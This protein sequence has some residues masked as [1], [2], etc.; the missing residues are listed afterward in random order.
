MRCTRFCF[1]LLLPGLGALAGPVHADGLKTGLWQSTLSQ[2]NALGSVRPVTRQIC[3]SDMSVRI[4]QAEQD[5]LKDRATG[6]DSCKLT[7]HGTPDDRS[8]ELACTGYSAS[9]SF[10]QPDPD[11]FTT[12]NAIKD[13]RGPD[14]ARFGLTTTRLDYSWVKAD[15]G[16]APEFR[17]SPTIGGTDSAPMSAVT[18]FRTGQMYERGGNGFAQ[19]YGQAMQHYLAAAAQGNP[20]AEFRIGYLYEKG[21]GVP[22]DF[23]Q[24][25]Q[26]YAKA[27]AHGNQTAATREENLKARQPVQ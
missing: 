23:N 5:R 8:V 1:W 27:A 6:L 26:W 13:D 22:Q 19:D 25:L 12:I 2:S 14:T 18:E 16:Q 21:W 7:D 15:C 17:G 11:H 3:F 4:L 20:V 10:S 9:T 24:A